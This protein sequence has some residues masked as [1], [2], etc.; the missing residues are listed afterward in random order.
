MQSQA[1]IPEIVAPASEDAD[2][3]S[4]SVA[5]T[6]LPDPNL[7]FLIPQE[8]TRPRPRSAGGSNRPTKSE[9]VDELVRFFETHDAPAEEQE[10]PM[11]Q[12]QQQ[13]QQNSRPY[14]IALGIFKAGHRRLRQFKQPKNDR[15][16]K[17]ETVE[18][19]T[20]RYIA[21]P[22]RVSLLSNLQAEEEQ[23]ESEIPE[24]GRLDGRPGLVNRNGDGSES[25]VLSG[26]PPFLSEITTRDENEGNPDDRFYPGLGE[27]PSLIGFS[28]PSSPARDVVSSNDKSSH[29]ITEPQNSLYNSTPSLRSE[30]SNLERTPARVR[31]DVESTGAAASKTVRHYKSAKING[32]RNDND[33]RHEQET[34]NS[35]VSIPPSSEGVAAAAENNPALLLRTGKGRAETTEST[36]SNN[37]NNNNW[38]HDGSPEW[39]RS[40]PAT[41]SFTHAKN[42]SSPSPRL[43]PRHLKPRTSLQSIHERTTWRRPTRT[44]QHKS[45]SR[46]FLDR[47]SR[48]R[49]PSSHSELLFTTTH[50]GSIRP[51]PL[52][53]E[54]FLPDAM[55][56][57]VLMQPPTGSTPERAQ[58]H[59]KF[60]DFE[61]DNSKSRPASSANNVPYNGSSR[62]PPRPAPTKPLPSLPKNKTPR[63]STCI[64]ENISQTPSRTQPD[65]HQSNVETT[66][67]Q[68]SGRPGKLAKSPSRS[69]RR[70]RSA[71]SRSHNKLHEGSP[72]MQ[73]ASGANRPDEGDNQQTS[74]NE[75]KLSAE[76]QERINRAERVYAVRMKDICAARAR[77][78][79]KMLEVREA[80]G[81]AMADEFTLSESRLLSTRDAERE[82]E[83]E[84]GARQLTPNPKH[85]RSQDGVASNNDRN[86][87]PSPRL[88]T[89]TPSPPPKVP[90]PADPPLPLFGTFSIESILR[91]SPGPSNRVLEMSPIMTVYEQRPTP[92]VYQRKHASES[93]SDRKR[94]GHHDNRPRPTSCLYWETNA[95][96]GRRG[97]QTDVLSRSSTILT[98]GKATPPRSTSPSLTSLDGEQ[99][100][101]RDTLHHAPTADHE[102][103]THFNRNPGYGYG[104][105]E[106]Q[107]NGTVPLN[108]MPAIP[109]DY[110]IPPLS[111]RVRST[112]PQTKTA[113]PHF[114]DSRHQQ[115]RPQSQQPRPQPQQRNSETVQYLESRIVT[116]ERQNKMLQ[117]ALMSALDVGVTLDAEKVRS[118]TPM[119]TGAP[120]DSYDSGQS[121]NPRPTRSSNA[122]S[123]RP[124]SW[125]SVCS[126]QS[127]RSLGATSSGS[128]GTGVKAIEA[129]IGNLE[130][131]W[132]GEPQSASDQSECSTARDRRV[133][134]ET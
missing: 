130:L 87:M 86:A 62:S 33:D 90:L 15:W 93:R 43:S 46:I 77:L 27:L 102:W 100:G 69:I 24:D 5:S 85:G 55:A 12:Q 73:H 76:R 129:M 60:P 95:P 122:I 14:K 71:L 115:H 54:S 28:L 50:A 79:N 84:T 47:P 103:K 66:E 118:G 121:P 92:Q 40:V 134:Y 81:D 51:T 32:F 36:E 30:Q 72:H 131:G 125:L 117:A 120:T 35:E 23:Q 106:R 98:N 105:P 19:R 114:P 123:R 13:Q 52:P 109:R 8:D 9:E 65:G 133:Q 110:Y 56:S 20:Y 6:P 113:E 70:T 2:W 39:F 57:S 18:G 1:P 22:N 75:Q 108:P 58:S 63:S 48:Y 37:N 68:A 21:V 41:K 64:H 112:Q 53:E 17:K 104:S 67:V 34:K 25:S 42:R 119:R 97:K 61:N 29:E 96:Q 10:Q 78:E 11:Q 44:L 126:A 91:G 132:S 45:T 80:G 116:L 127:R 82:A 49:T 101:Q 88:P 83:R 94:G 4:H 74:I 124:N 89:T 26:P 7:G 99:P 3:E 107:V 16:V 59:F 38:I 111:P 31:F 128:E